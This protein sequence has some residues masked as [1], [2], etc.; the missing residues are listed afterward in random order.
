MAGGGPGSVVDVAAR[1]TSIDRAEAILRATKE[2]AAKV[3]H[4]LQTGP[5]GGEYYVGPSGEKVYE[6]KNPGPVIV[7]DGRDG[8]GRRY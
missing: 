5:R 3:E 6:S 7:L 8:N 4:A 2:R 1:K